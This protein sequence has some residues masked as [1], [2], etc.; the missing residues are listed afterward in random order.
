MIPPFFEEFFDGNRHFRILDKTL[1]NRSP[2][3]NMA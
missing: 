1:V 3:L 2:G